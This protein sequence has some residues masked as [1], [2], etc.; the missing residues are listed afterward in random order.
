LRGTV[1]QTTIENVASD[2]TRIVDDFRE[3]HE[4]A[5][6]GAL[7]K[8]EQASYRLVRERLSALLCAGQQLSSKPGLR[9]RQSFRLATVWPLV[10]EHDGVSEST[11]TMDLSYGG[12]SAVLD[13]V[14]PNATRVR[15]AMRLPAEKIGGQ[16][17]LV[18]GRAVL[19]HFRASFAFDT[20]E[21]A[22]RD[23]LDFAIS[24]A[25]LAHLGVEGT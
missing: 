7:N 5:R 6:K 18:G 16:A 10:I 20:L 8:I 1:A 25:V 12:F 17:R 21:P 22:A 19:D 11:S 24:D 23:I 14:L 4:K 13:R 3:L 2:P 9:P 15:F